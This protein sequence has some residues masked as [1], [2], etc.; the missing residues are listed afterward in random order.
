MAGDL[1]NGFNGLP[2]AAERAKR[3]G[4]RG[5]VVGQWVVK[6]NFVGLKRC[7]IPTQGW[8]NSLQVIVRNRLAG[9][10]ALTCQ[11]QQWYN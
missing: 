10:F 7:G 1:Q 2:E 11:P 4:I 3:R 6:A 8:D 5:T 9:I